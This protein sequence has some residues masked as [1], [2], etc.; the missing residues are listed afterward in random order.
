MNAYQFEGPS[1]VVYHINWSRFT[2]YICYPT[3][4]S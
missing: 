2:S 1:S 4:T 3:F